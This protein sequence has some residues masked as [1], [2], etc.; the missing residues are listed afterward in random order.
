MSCPSHVSSKEF[1]REVVL[2]WGRVET[3]TSKTDHTKKFS[4]LR[5][6]EEIDNCL[7]WMVV[8]EKISHTTPA[9]S[10]SCESC[11]KQ[12]GRSAMWE[13][14]QGSKKSSIMCLM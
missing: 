10:W 8:G 9:S 2:G 14:V 7:L 5:L 1:F 4:G 3:F 13:R 11:L 6:G 12:N